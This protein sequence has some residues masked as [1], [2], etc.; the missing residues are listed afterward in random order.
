MNQGKYDNYFSKI[1]EL[2]SQY[3]DVASKKNDADFD[4]K[5]AYAYKT[6]R[7][8]IIL[9]VC[10]VYFEYEIKKDS[11]KSNKTIIYQDINDDNYSDIVVE[12]IINALDSYESSS[13][14][15]KGYQF[16]YFVCINIRQEIGKERSK[17]YVSVNHGGTEVSDYEAT[18]TRRILK[19]DK[20]LQKMGIYDEEKRNQKLAVLLDIGIE[21]VQKYIAL[22]KN[23][24]TSTELE[25]DG[26]TYSKLD[27]ENNLQERNFITPESE[28]IV[29]EMKEQIPLMLNEMESIFLKKPDVKT[30]ELL[31]ISI[32]EYFEPYRKNYIMSGYPLSG[33]CPILRELISKY[34]CIDSKITTSFFTDPDYVLPT[35]KDITDKYGLDKSA[36]TQILTRFREKLKDKENIKKYFS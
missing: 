32:L 2:Y 21:T 35:R 30:A 8:K 3:V 34:S 29:N 6:I 26:R 22:G 18:M 20:E 24:T 5:W 25:K 4:K 13:S 11:D 17:A 1:N 28:Y 9:A 23:Q 33:F 7:E 36:A 27:L 19:K 15:E 14:K 31:A 10:K 16:S 12:E